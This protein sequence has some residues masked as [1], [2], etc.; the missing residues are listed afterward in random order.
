MSRLRL[1]VAAAAAALAAVSVLYMVQA[2]MAVAATPPAGA[3]MVAQAP[4]GGAGGG[5]GGWGQMSEAERAKMREQMTARMLDQAGLTDAE[6]TAAKKA[7]TAKARAREALTQELTKLRRTANQAKPTDKDLR[8]AL[9]AYGAALTQY[10]KQVAATDA[11]LVKQLSTRSRAR[12]MSLGILDNGL[13]MMGRMGGGGQSG[14]G[15][16]RRPRG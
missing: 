8:A 4:G 15:G 13:G 9:A 3:V 2:R 16:A 12:C 1:A 7:L 5:P 11:A 6:K 10:R 14:P